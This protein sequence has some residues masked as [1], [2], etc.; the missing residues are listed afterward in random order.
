M[1][2]MMK[3]TIISITGLWIITVLGILT[4][5]YSQSQ[6]GI[7]GIVYDI[8][9]GEPVPFVHVSLFDSTKSELITGDVSDMDGKYQMNVESGVAG[10]LR[11]SAVGYETVWIEV[12][13]NGSGITDLGRTGLHF[14]VTEHEAIVVLGVLPVRSEPGRTS[15]YMDDK[16][17]RTAVTGTDLLKVIPGIEV[18]FMQ[19]ITIEGGRNVVLLVDGVER[20][21]S[22][23]GQLQSDKIDRIDVV[24]MPPVGYEADISGAVNIIL[25]K[26]NESGLSGHVHG[27]I[28]VSSTER[29]LFPTTSIQYTKNRVNVYGS[30]SGDFRKFDLSES[31]L[32]EGRSGGD[33]IGGHNLQ[34]LDQLT[35]SNTIHLGADY[36]MNRRHRAG[37]YALYQNF[38][39]SLDGLS[40]LKTTGNEGVWQTT[41]KFDRESSKTNYYSMSYRFQ[42]SGESGNEL[43]LNG[44]LEQR[45]GSNWVEYREGSGIGNHSSS[46]LPE[47]IHFRVKADAKTAIRDNIQIEYGAL[48]RWRNIEDLSQPDFSYSDENIAV[49]SSIHHFS[50]NSGIQAGMRFEKMESNT[51]NDLGRSSAKLFPA[52]SVYHRFEKSSHRLSLSY[53][54]SVNY[55]QLYQVNPNLITEDLFSSLS[56]NPALVPSI[57]KEL[58]FEHSFHAGKHFF[59]TRVYTTYTSDSMDL[60]T[61]K[62]EPGRMVSQFMNAGNVRRVGVRVSGAIDAGQKSGFH[63][64][65]NI[66]S[67]KISLSDELNILPTLTN[68]KIMLE[69]GLSAST[70]VGRDFHI[71]MIFQYST[72]VYEIQR[73]N[74]SGALYFINIDKSF[75]SGLS[76]GMTTALTFSKSFLYN[77]YTMDTEGFYSRSEGTINMSAIPVWLKVNYRFSKGSS[78][79]KIS[80]DIERSGRRSGRGF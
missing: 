7:T 22:F 5:L 40:D 19:N 21:R 45:S 52:A 70:T 68:P 14:S 78:K 24:N 69:S 73:T 31:T 76:I 79:D 36:F 4:P 1:E 13:T 11:L 50:E 20:D 44:G 32:F 6:A 37:F 64:Y 47:E 58:G 35:R 15:F 42:P 63:P 18:D 9:L 17:T 41:E 57:N 71:S 28:P 53:R 16:I 61:E 43:R 27:E 59:S 38:S 77:G 65:L 67:K 12:E 33:V 29:Y 60:I 25:K 2:K 66:Y 10:Y 23:M 55:P 62:G 34:T 74:F 8:Q 3:P 75:S 30:Y 54:V 72:P 26:N 49:Y 80:H 51:G 46:Q 39:Q 56:G 48:F